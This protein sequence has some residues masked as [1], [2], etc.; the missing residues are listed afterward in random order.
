MKKIIVIL[1][2]VCS[3]NCIAQTDSLELYKQGYKIAKELNIEYKSKIESTNEVIHQL[4][5]QTQDLNE[6]I[7]TSDYILYND[8]LQLDIQSQQIKLLNDNLN[9]YQKEFNRRNKFWNKPVFG[10]ILGMV[11]TITLIHVIDYSLPQ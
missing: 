6:I 8:S 9:I 3:I 10:V 5:L 4:Q 7:K 11:G 1:L 2:T